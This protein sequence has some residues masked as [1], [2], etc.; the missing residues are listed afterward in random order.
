MNTPAPY[1]WQLEQWSRICRSA[2][3]GRLHHATLISGQAGVGKR[4][5]AVAMAR[6]L[7]CL[8]FP[9]QQQPCGQC[10]RCQ[11]MQ[12]G[13]HP[14]FTVVDWLD[15]SSV[16]SVDQ[17]RHLSSQLH[18]T[19]TYGPYRIAIINRADTMTAAACN[20]LL[21]TLEEPPGSCVLILLSERDAA[22]PATIHSRC[23]R[24][25]MPAPEQ[26]AA[27]EWL[28]QQEIAEAGIA[29]E[30]ARGAPLLAATFARERDLAAIGNIREQWRQFLLAEKSPA[31]L[32][33]ETANLLDTRES[34]TL[35]M[36]WTTDLVKNVEFSMADGRSSPEGALIERKFLSQALQLLQQSLRF[37]NASLKTLAVLEGVL[38]DIRIQRIRTRAENSA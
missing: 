27:L 35:F 15:K 12:A 18:L 31:A 38:A 3:D 34:L 7:L 11:L 21:K 4:D 19:A 26:Q 1:P 10:A 37:D 28:Q 32:A 30:F 5:F 20:S 36:Q 14:D 33:A 16:I 8:E 9:N 25:L 29:L 6:L 22:L 17:I 2:A 24:L 23:Q 13:T